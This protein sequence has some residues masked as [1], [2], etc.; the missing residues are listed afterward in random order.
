VKRH[1]IEVDEARQKGEFGTEL[2]D[3]GGGIAVRL[4]PGHAAVYEV[5]EPHTK[6]DQGPV[7]LPVAQVVPIKTRRRVGD[8]GAKYHGT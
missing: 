3:A 8:R 5:G 4:A 2:H 6:Q 1:Q 7:P